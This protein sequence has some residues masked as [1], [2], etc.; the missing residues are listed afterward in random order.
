[1][2]RIDSAPEPKAFARYRETHPQ[3]RDWNAFGSVLLSSLD[4]AVEDKSKTLKEHASEVLARNQSGLC[5]YCEMRLPAKGDR[6][7]E[8]IHPKSDASTDHNWVLDWN[9]LLVVCHG[10]KSNNVWSE[11][12]AELH[13]DASK[14]DDQTA[15]LNPYLMPNACLFSLDRKT[16]ELNPDAGACS[17]VDA[18][19]SSSVSMRD[20]VENTIRVLNLNCRRLCE[21][22]KTVIKCYKQRY[23]VVQRTAKG[24]VREIIAKEWFGSNRVMEF[25]TARRCLLGGK[26]NPYLSP[27]LR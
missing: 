6:R 21:L 10:G 5:A 18:E 16:G 12:E 8:H 13:C 27:D 11:D 20:I 7:I 9:N 25:Y 23:Q 2:H 14:A 24:S 22:R 3:M 17:V 26:V 19:N 1:M 15:I 4:P